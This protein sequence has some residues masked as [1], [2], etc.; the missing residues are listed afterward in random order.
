MLHQTT[1]LLGRFRP[2]KPHV[3]R[4]TASQIVSASATS[5]LLPSRKP[6]RSFAG[7]KRT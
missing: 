2:H 4:R 3:G 7:I 5:F 6:S 1:L